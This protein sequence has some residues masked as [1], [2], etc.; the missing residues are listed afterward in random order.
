MWGSL[1]P[2]CVATQNGAGRRGVPKV[3]P[4]TSI[5][6]AFPPG[7]GPPGGRAHTPRRE[8]CTVATTMAARAAASAAQFQPET[9]KRSPS[10]T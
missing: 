4:V 2:G 8:S 7:R 5:G 3:I 1:Q 10:T 9:W 6:G